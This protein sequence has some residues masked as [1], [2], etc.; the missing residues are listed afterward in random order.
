MWSTD[1]SGGDAR[2]LEDEPEDFADDDR[3]FCQVGE[4]VEAEE[5]AQPKAKEEAKLEAEGARQ[6]AEEEERLKAEKWKGDEEARHN[7]EGE[8]E[9]KAQDARLKAEQEVSLDKVESDIVMVAPYLDR[10]CFS[11]Q[12]TISGPF[13]CCTKCHFDLCTDCMEPCKRDPACAG[14]FCWQCVDYHSCRNPLPRRPPRTPERTPE[15]QPDCMEPCKSCLDLIPSTAAQV[16]AYLGPNLDFDVC[17]IE[18]SLHVTRFAGYATGNGVWILE[19]KGNLAHRLEVLGCERREEQGLSPEQISLRRIAE[20]QVESFS[21]KCGWRV[22][23]LGDSTHEHG[24][25]RPDWSNGAQIYLHPEHAEHI[26]TF[27]RSYDTK[28]LHSRNIVISNGYL[29]LLLRLM[30]NTHCFLTRSARPFRG[31]FLERSRRWISRACWVPAH[32]YQPQEVLL[33]QRSV[34]FAS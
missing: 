8:K 19:L 14:K 30:V 34:S 20:K 3:W 31:A 24:P 23:Q 15:P 11:C 29:P 13:T 25:E 2:W 1:E 28:P 33:D 22:R 18:R 6:K 5:K 21:V 17:H 4:R 32:D 10:E 27:F 16:D 9:A 26:E 7:Q 12:R